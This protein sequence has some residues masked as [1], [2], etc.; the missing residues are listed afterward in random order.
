MEVANIKVEKGRKLQKKQLTVN[1]ERL[2]CIPVLAIGRLTCQLCEH[3]DENI[4]QEKA[5]TVR[6]LERAGGQLH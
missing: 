3:T 4:R 2:F 1:L 5:E 6:G